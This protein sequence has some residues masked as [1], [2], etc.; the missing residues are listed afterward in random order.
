MS[1]WAQIL[2]LLGLVIMLGLIGVVVY[3][4]KQSAANQ[5][6]E[7]LVQKL[8]SQAFGL[9][10]NSIAEQ[11][12][13]ILHSDKELIKSELEAKHK[14]LD[15]LVTQ[16]QTD[17]NERQR[18]IRSLEQDRS[19]KFNQLAT[20]LADHRKLV[21]ELRISTQQLASVLSNNQQRG[22]WGERIIEDLLQANGMVENVHY[23]RQ[24]FL[25][26]SNL[27]PDITLLP[28][29]RLVAVDVKFPYQEIQKLAAA[30]SKQAKQA[31]LKQF[32]IDLRVKVNKVAEYILPSSDTL[33]YAILFVPNE[34]VFSFVNQ[35]MPGVIDEA[36]SKKVM[37][38]SPFTFL[39][40]ARTL[41][42]SYRNFM[43]GG[44]LREVVAAVGDFLHEWEMFHEEFSKFGRTLLSLQKGYDVLT[45]TRV[46]QMQRRI[47]GIEKTQAGALP[48]A[49]SGVTS[50]AKQSKI[51]RQLGT[52]LIDEPQISEATQLSTQ[53]EEL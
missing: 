7:S 8:V 39:I 27:K 18:E 13:A 47:S 29:N 36:M 48:S 46:K 16:L 37:I 5:L 10:A 33:D 20:S 4:L 24:T 15:K 30:D 22:E 41:L 34:M 26:D 51:S 52:A 11:S 42:E 49:D 31:H 1:I 23:K 40:V 53:E 17:L 25:S 45:T 3:L 19:Q 21:D 44:R 14:A 35:K 12:R 43:V 32:E 28:D 6:D 9:S 50:T 38:V 2:I